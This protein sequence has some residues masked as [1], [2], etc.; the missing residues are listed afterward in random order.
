[1]SAVPRQTE[2]LDSEMRGVYSHLM[3]YARGRG[4]DDPVACM[5]ATWRYGGGALPAWMGLGCEDYRAMMHHHFPGV[6]D[7]MPDAVRMA[8]LNRADEIDELQRL[9][10]LNRANQS[11]SE[12]WLA[13]IIAVGCMGSDHLWQDMGL[14]SRRDLTSLMNRNFPSLRN[15]KNMKWKK[16]LY[17][18]LCE[19]EG[20][21]T[22]RSP[23]CEVCADY[24]LCF[25]TED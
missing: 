13:T 21:Y 17:K 15:E 14:W 16:Y 5:F 11:E 25:S 24:Q 20:I 8:P 1:M 7:E 23:S 12:R 10:L 22:C 4:N 3:A 18:Q 9:L 6:A 19:T 2:S